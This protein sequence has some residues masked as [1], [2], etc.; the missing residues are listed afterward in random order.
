MKAK[1][2]L[3][4]LALAGFGG[5]AFSLSLREIRSVRIGKGN[6]SAFGVSVEISPVIGP[7]EQYYGV[8]T[9]K[10]DRQYRVTVTVPKIVDGHAL[11][12]ILVSVNSGG[13]Q[14]VD[15]SAF[16]ATKDEG[17][18]ATAFVFMNAET[19]GIA[20]I[21]ADY[22]SSDFIYSI[23]LPSYF[24]D[25]EE[26]DSANQLPEATPGQRPPTASTQPPGA[27]QR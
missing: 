24:S 27:P 7:I 5:T 21:V 3:L 2:F 18:H 15:I 4:V 6:G 26:K 1:H 12:R 9:R 19:I 16:V 25:S 14:K 23:D 11:G 22:G 10:A 20:S 8:P 17:N 13:P